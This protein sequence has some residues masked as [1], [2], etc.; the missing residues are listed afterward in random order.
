[1]I[2]CT[3]ERPQAFAFKDGKDSFG[4]SKSFH[5][6]ASVTAERHGC[7]CNMF[8][9]VPQVSLSLNTLLHLI[10]VVYIHSLDMCVTQQP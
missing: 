3:Q 2:L 9:P 4:L 7:T 6:W 1:M 5:L 10:Y 8:L